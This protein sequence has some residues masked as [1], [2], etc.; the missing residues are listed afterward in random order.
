MLSV[1]Q[2]GLCLLELKPVYRRATCNVLW[3]H[4]LDEKIFRFVLYSEKR[5]VCVVEVGIQWVMDCNDFLK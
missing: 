2:M 5:L 4:W 1:Y 3:K